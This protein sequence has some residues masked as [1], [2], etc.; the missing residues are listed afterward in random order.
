MATLHGLIENPGLAAETISESGLSKP[1]HNFTPLS[2]LED[3]LS[4]EEV[5]NTNL[6]RVKVRAKD[7]TI[8]A[9][10]SRILAQKAVRL[11]RRLDQEQGSSLQEQLKTHLDQAAERLKTAED[12]YLTYQKTAQ[13]DLLKEDANAQLDERGDLLRL[14]IQIESEK[15]RLAAA[16][17]EIG[18]QERVLSVGRAVGAE[19]ALR[20]ALDSDEQ[21]TA[22]AA[23]HRSQASTTTAEP[24]SAGAQ[25]AG[26]SN[27]PDARR[28]QDQSNAAAVRRSNTN[29]T[30]PE[31]PSAGAETVDQSNPFIN[32]V[33]QTLDLT[34]ATSRARLAALQ[35]QRREVVE[36]RKLGGQDLQKLSELYS[37]QI[38]L[39]RLSNAYDVA[40]RV[41]S[42]LLV[43]YEQARTETVEN[44]SQVQLVDGAIPPE[45]PLPQRRAQ[46]AV[47]GLVAGLFSAALLAL[48]LGSPRRDIAPA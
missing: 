29:T 17:Q 27:Q 21:A 10:A 13:V 9:N 4:V 40:K 23:A 16:E 11:S 42:D 34:I 25:T 5:R 24:R 12:Q 35:Q 28:S 46:S 37:R 30:T 6:V 14:T 15:A 39:A 31:P 36:V 33:Y 1:P 18:R 26:Q 38:E 3:A 47:L 45:K 44:A 19:A 8:A 41:Y 20:R 7:P 22:A 32:P 2:F 43:R 48:V